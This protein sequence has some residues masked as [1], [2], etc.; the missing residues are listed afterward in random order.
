MKSAQKWLEGNLFDTSIWNILIS[1]NGNWQMTDTNITI[2]N[3][4]QS[5]VDVTGETPRIRSVGGQCSVSSSKLSRYL[6]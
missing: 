2:Q 3:K 1:L 6:E 4:F 5:V